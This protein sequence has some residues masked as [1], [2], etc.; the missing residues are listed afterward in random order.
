MYLKD[1]RGGKKRLSK[2]R[3]LDPRYWEMGG[4]RRVLRPGDP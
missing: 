2:G 4:N 1:F 3:V